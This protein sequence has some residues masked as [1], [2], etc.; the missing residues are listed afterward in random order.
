MIIAEKIVNTEKKIITDNEEYVITKKHKIIVKDINEDDLRT[1]CY[2]L[3][4]FDDYE[5]AYYT[6]GIGSSFTDDLYML[7]VE[8][9]LQGLKKYCEDE[10]NIFIDDAKTWIENLTKYEDY[11]LSF[12]EIAKEMKCH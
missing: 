4:V 6:Y 9:F 10:D 12:E 2:D 1:F 7:D 8:K 11:N 5:S 3:N